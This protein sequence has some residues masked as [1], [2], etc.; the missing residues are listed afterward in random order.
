MQVDRYG[1][2]LSTTNPAAGQ[3]Y[4]NAV[5]SL[6]GAM[7]GDQ[8]GFEEAIRLDPDFALAYIGLARALAVR[9]Q[10]APAREAAARARALSQAG[11]E[12]VHSHVHALALLVEGQPVAAFEAIRDHLARWP[13]D[14]M[15]LSP[16]SGVFG[17]IGFSGRQARETEMYDF[18]KALA[19]QYS[20]DWW[21]EMSLAFAACETG[22]LDE[23]MTLIERSLSR[24]PR[25][26]NGAHI[27]AHVLYEMGEAEQGLA[28]LQ[29]WIPDYDRAAI[30]HGHLSWHIALFAL[31]TGRTQLAWQVFEDAVDPQVNLAP[32]LNVASDA[33]SFVWRADLAAQQSNPQLR[34]RIRDY[35]VERF[36]KAGVSFADVHT[37]MACAAA[38]DQAH[39][40]Q[41][42]DQLRDRLENNKLP[43]GAVVPLLVDALCA[44]G[45]QDWPGAVEMLK[46][47][48]PLTVRIGG[49]RAQRDLIVLTLQAALHKVREVEGDVDFVPILLPIMRG[50]V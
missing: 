41:L 11:D 33:A 26:G 32:P 13:R 12:R 8:S 42:A 23:A 45:R 50:P 20:D 28:Y 7:P 47:A 38:G 49:S 37:A 46:E 18:F 15:V 22:R 17:L 36:P 27:R 6:L 39:C 24:Q 2:Q 25:S 3:A 29:Q 30:M 21:F 9:M 4:V 10:A 16:A 34:Q 1:F 31:E 43:A 19:S 14:A 35:C 40:A 44:Y 5:D 48:L